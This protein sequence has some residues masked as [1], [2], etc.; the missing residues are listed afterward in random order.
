MLALIKIEPRSE[1]P[2]YRQLYSQL[3]RSI[4]EG[5]LAAG[6]RLPSTRILARALGVSRNTV[7]NAYDWL[8]ADAL[9][10]ARKGSGTYVNTPNDGARAAVATATRAFDLRTAVRE[11][12]FP[13]DSVWLHDP[14]GNPLY[15][16]R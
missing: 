10:A 8:A 9:I 14:E 16:H 5:R 1:W 15:V 12:L 6:A 3:R 7:L 4:L 13:A 2:R 11:A